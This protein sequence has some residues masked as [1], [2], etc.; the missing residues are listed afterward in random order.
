M[1]GDIPKRFFFEYVSAV[2]W[3]GKA[4]ALNP[5][6]NRRYLGNPAKQ[7]FGLPYIL[8]N[9]NTLYSNSKKSMYNVRYFVYKNSLQ[10]RVYSEPV[11]LKARMEEVAFDRSKQKLGRFGSDVVDLEN[12]EILWNVVDDFEDD[13]SDFMM[14][15]DTF[16]F[17]LLDVAYQEELKRK[18][19]D[20][21]RSSVGRTKRNIVYLSRSNDWDWM[22][23]FTLN[24]EKVDRYDYAESSK[25]VR[26]FLNNLRRVAPDMVYLIVPELHEDGAWHFHGLMNG[27]EALEWHDS[28]KYDSEGRKVYN[29]QEYR[30]GWSYCSRVDTS[31]KAASYIMK[32]ITKELCGKT[33]NQRRYWNSKNINR[34]EVFEAMVYGDDL[35]VL[36]DKLYDEMTWKK[37]V[38]TAYQDVEIFEVPKD[39]VEKYMEE[40]NNGSYDTD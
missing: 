11:C 13:E 6:E 33:K 9:R 2:V 7:N 21:L 36:V 40:L 24:P 27:V 16:D 3:S 12:G 32:Y 39:F 5:G 37:K 20:S 4:R 18:H 15:P 28:G 1:S 25:K 38:F 17:D 31:D 22:V 34:A 14:L 26:K 30:L 8:D 35:K 19:E 23:T 29:M 10:F